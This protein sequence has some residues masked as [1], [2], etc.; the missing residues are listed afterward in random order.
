[1]EPY[2]RAGCS[3]ESRKARFF[4]NTPATAEAHTLPG[5]TQRRMTPLNSWLHDHRSAPGPSTKWRPRP[6]PRTLSYPQCSQGSVN[7]TRLWPVL[8][9]TCRVVQRNGH[10]PARL[11]PSGLLQA[12]MGTPSASPRPRGVDCS[13]KRKTKCRVWTH[14]TARD[15]HRELGT[16]G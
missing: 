6:S 11:C 16:W 5:R 13:R 15:T 12:R 9:P 4:S 10:R 2:S 8:T 1:M 7:A 14:L 3:P